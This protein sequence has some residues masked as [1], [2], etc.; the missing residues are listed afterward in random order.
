MKWFKHD[1][2]ANMDDKLQ[3]VL[4]DYGLEGY[5]L[6]WYC[7]ELINA[8]VET[9]NLTFELKHDARVIARNTGSTRQKVEE[10][11]KRFVELGLFESSQGVI[12]CLKL[13]RRL[14][15]SMTGNPSMRKLIKA[16][17]SHDE[18]TDS[19]DCKANSHDSI[20]TESDSVMIL[21]DQKRKEENRTEENRT[22]DIKDLSGE[23]DDCDQVFA[24]WKEVMNSDMSRLTKERKTKI[25]A[26]L[27][28]GYTVDQLKQAILGCSMTPHNMGQNDNGKKYNCISLICRDGSHVE[29]FA[30]NSAQAPTPIYSA[31][32]AH[33]INVLKN[34]ELD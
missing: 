19:H 12:T 29:R 33:N 28:E 20:M 30:G 22:E 32:T 34:V 23:P 26:R 16:L 24:Y 1:S 17:H 6:Y 8:K 21:S 11:M 2:D 10:M 31:T 14:D 4:L 25:K 9:N 3:E 7:I 5:G 18:T 27:K 13:G 15:Q